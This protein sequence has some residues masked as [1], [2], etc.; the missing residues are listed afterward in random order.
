LVSSR[1][2]L[3]RTVL[4]AAALGYN[5]ADVG[6]FADDLARHFDVGLG[7]IGLITT[8]LL[9][10]HAAVQLPA[11]NPIARYGPDRVGQA[12]FALLLVTNAAAAAA[13]QLGVLDGVRAL[14]GVGTGVAF[15]ACLEA[16]RRDGGAVL[17]GVFGGVATFGVG[18]SLAVGAAL[19][20]HGGWRASFAI[21][22]LLALAA[23]IAIPAREPD[24][25]R[26]L[27]ARGDVRAVLGHRALWRL[28]FVHMMTFGCSLVLGA[29]IVSY[30]VRG[31]AHS[32]AVAGLAGF[33]V[34]AIGG[35]V[36]PLGGVLLVRGTSW[37]ALV[38]AAAAAASLGLLAL[39]LSRSPAAVA[40]AVVLCG[41]GFALPF[42]SIFI[43]AARAE[44]VRAAAASA[45]V[46]LIGGVFALAVTPLVGADI[47]RSGGGRAFLALAVLAALAAL[48][49]RREPVA[50]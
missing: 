4:G 6:P 45:F 44:P 8:A 20:S 21:A 14:M 32:H 9:A 37:S 23:T 46:N 35:L 3:L 36:R 10:T 13:Q 5:F 41:V 2:A 22:A 48:L 38:P 15:V 7:A 27:A 50:A 30:L 29:W 16:A 11:A 31:A 33:A 1:R 25:G 24:A 28:G 26:R 39:A 12:A 34:L 42:S 47:D 18:L 17:A 19:G 49:N 40:L 43:A